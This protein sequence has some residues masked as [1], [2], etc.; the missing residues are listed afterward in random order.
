MR[1]EQPSFAG[2]EIAPPLYARIDTAKYA[3]ALKRC[4]NFLV[5]KYGGVTRRPGTRLVGTIAGKTGAARLIPF[6]FS[7]DDAYVLEFTNLKMRV[8]RNGAYVL[9][10][11]PKTITGITQAAQGV[12]TSTAHGLANGSEV[13]LTGIV[14]MTQLNGRTLYVSDATADTFKLKDVNAAYVNTS[15]YGAYVSGGTATMLYE[16]TTPYAAADLFDIRFEQSADVMYLAHPTYAPRK[17][18]RTDHNAWSIATVTFATSLA[19]PTGLGAVESGGG[20]GVQYD[21]Y[22]TAFDT[23]T[24]DE[25]VV[26]SV[27]TIASGR[28]RNDGGGDTNKHTLTWNSVTGANRYRVYKQSGGVL[29]FMGS[30]DQLSMIDDGIEQDSTDT[31]P[32]ARNPFNATGDYPGAVTFFEQRLCWGG[33]D[34]K[35]NGFW[36]SRSGNFENMNVSFPTRD[37]DAITAGLVAREVNVV[38]HLVPLE[39]LLVLTSAAVFRIN[40]GGQSD[41]IGPASFISRVQAYRGASNVRPVVVDSVVLYWQARGAQLR[42]LGY[43]FDTD[44]YRGSD[45]TIFAPHFFKG[46]TIVDQ[47]YTQ[48]PLSVLW[49]VGDDGILYALTWEL[50]QDVWGWSRCET[51]GGLV[52]SVAAIPQDGEDVLYAVVER[53]IGGVARSY[54]ERLTTSQWTAVASAVYMDCAVS[55]SGAAATTFSGLEYLEGEEVVAL[56]DG[57]VVAGL[58]V[59]GGAVTLATAASNVSVGLA[60][61]SLIETLPPGFSTPGTSL[62]GVKKSANLLTVRVEDTRGL[63]FGLTDDD[64]T[65]FKAR[66]D[67]DDLDSPPAL[68]TGDLEASLP[69]TWTTNPTFVIA[70]TYPLPAT[71][72]AVFPA[73]QIGG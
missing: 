6:R 9:G 12:V 15:T 10:T 43:Q 8:I 63:S 70:Q 47:A 36:S 2:G 38:Q 57:A 34:N 52:K 54:V 20:D 64:L 21:Y 4:R 18:T 29:G 31:P 51:E 73:I 66:T 14:G 30:T 19:A 5:Q 23:E 26:S 65:E 40:G 42:T 22:V 35:P 44:G 68:F 61:T 69:P 46:R 11:A 24:G 28:L 49:A 27:A 59:S 62:Q 41:F 39:D 56:A 45:L 60:Y 16:L 55:Y 67:D 17:L 1:Y 71:I 58:T 48:H 32:E 50:E 53:T 3:T 72:T 7:A 13:Y 25:S 33:S 37:D